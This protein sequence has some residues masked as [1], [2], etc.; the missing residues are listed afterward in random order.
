MATRLAE[1]QGARRP[2]DVEGTRAFR[3]VYA[4]AR[5]PAAAHRRNGSRG[6]RPGRQGATKASIVLAATLDLRHRQ[7]A[8]LA[9]RYVVGIQAAGVARI[10]GLSQNRTMELIRSASVNVSKAA[11]G[12]VDV[13]R[14]LRSIG[15]MVR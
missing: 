12:R 7:R 1:R 15:T 4:L 3:S 2:G 5:E 10:L 9:L 14:H 13:A 6:D 8:A 11:G